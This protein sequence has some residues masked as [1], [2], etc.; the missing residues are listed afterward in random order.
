MP[1]LRWSDW[2]PG[3]D[4]DHMTLSEV[5]ATLPGDDPEAIPEI[6]RKYENPASPD[7]LP[8]A[9]ALERHDCP[10]S[11]TSFWGQSTKRRIMS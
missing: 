11:P 8:G 2:S 4:N 9:V 10:R 6:I 3:L 7:A 5:M 1:Y